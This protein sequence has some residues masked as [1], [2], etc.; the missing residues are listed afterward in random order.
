M[1]RPSISR[2]FKKKEISRLLWQDARTV[3]TALRAGDPHYCI[4]LS[5]FEKLVGKVA[6]MRH[7]TIHISDYWSK[8]DAGSYAGSDEWTY[9]KIF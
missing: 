9:Y 4:Q 6:Q 5:L 8:P 3:L 2:D 7:Y 1:F